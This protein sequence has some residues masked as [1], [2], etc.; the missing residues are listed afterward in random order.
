MNNDR[1]DNRTPFAP[2]GEDVPDVKSMSAS[3]SDI[4]FLLEKLL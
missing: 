3:E 1:C 4:V 2:F